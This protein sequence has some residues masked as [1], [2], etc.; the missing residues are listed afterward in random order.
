MSYFAGGIVSYLLADESTRHMLPAAL[1]QE[2]HDELVLVL[3][4]SHCCDKTRLKAMYFCIHRSSF[5][6]ALT[7]LVTD[8]C[9]IIIIIIVIRFVMS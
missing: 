6:C 2:L 4:S 8:I 1:A 3:V 9:I 7:A 5:V